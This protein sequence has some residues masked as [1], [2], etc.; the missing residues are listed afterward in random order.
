MLGIIEQLLNDNIIMQEKLPRMELPCIGILWNSLE[1][2]L[3]AEA[4]QMLSTRATI[5]DLTFVDLGS[6]YRP[7]INEIY[8]YN[9]EKNRCYCF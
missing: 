3:M 2:D 6:E 5:E 8:L 4:I 7:F 9:N 1:G